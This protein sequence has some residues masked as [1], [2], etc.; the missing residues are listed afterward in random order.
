MCTC[1]TRWARIGLAAALVAAGAVTAVAAG[2]T[3][4]PADTGAA[5][6]VTYTV[7]WQTPSDNPPDF[8]VTVTV[9]N[10][11]AYPISTWAVSW[12]YTA[13]Q[14]VI[15]GSA[16]SAGVTQDGSVVTAVP[17]AGYNA[18]L[19][20][21]A[22]TTWGFHASYNG[23]SNPVPT[24][25]CAG[26]SQGSGSATLSGP[27]DPLGVNT[28]AW[29]TNFTD[30]AIAGDLSAASTG[31]IRYP[32][33]SWADQYLWQPN[34]VNGAAQPVNF[35]QYASQVDAISGGQK[36]VTVN[37]GSDTPQSAAAWVRQSATAGQG[38]NLWE[39][40]NEEYGSWETDNHASPH[41][42][43][44]YASNVDHGTGRQHPRCRG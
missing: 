14:H 1:V 40:G 41:T 34:T 15:A 20:A 12:T 23:T 7:A 2:A 5:C 30:P 29:D 10:N 37:Y 27:L 11:S 44:S 18:S 36:F 42:A 13:G 4:A 38:V 28:A 6:G 26:P 31:L 43:S 24:V 22:S 35:A 21:G 25:T 32:G 17:Q 3:R 16:Y 39:I 9:T 19:A 33:G 8:G